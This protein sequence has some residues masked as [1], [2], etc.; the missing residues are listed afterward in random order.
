[1]PMSTP[2]NKAAARRIFLIINL[3][4]RIILL[5]LNVRT[6]EFPGSCSTRKLFSL[7]ETV[8]L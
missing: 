4:I 8:M 7:P 1:M 6:G 5:N 2:I 3:L